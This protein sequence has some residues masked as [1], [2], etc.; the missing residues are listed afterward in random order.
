METDVIHGLE[1]ENIINH[2]RLGIKMF[3]IPQITYWYGNSLRCCFLDSWF[4]TGI[5]RSINRNEHLFSREI[6]CLL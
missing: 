4:K 6:A 3:S 1:D 2:E 5:L